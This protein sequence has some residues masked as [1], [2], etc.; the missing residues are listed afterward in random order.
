M[1]LVRRRLMTG[2][3]AAALLSGCPLNVVQTPAD[4]PMRRGP[5]EVGQAILGVTPDTLPLPVP[6]D[7]AF[8]PALATCD[9][10]PSP[11]MPPSEIRSV[12]YYPAVATSDDVSLRIRSRLATGAFPLVLFAHGR[13]YAPW[14]VTPPGIEASAT[15]VRQDFLKWDELLSHVASHGF[16]VVAPDLGWLLQ[17]LESRPWPDDPAA[18]DGPPRATL[19]ARL[20][21]QLAAR[22]DLFAD[23]M[24]HLRL[25]LVGHSTGAEACV[26]AAQ[27]L[28]QTKLLCML[29]PAILFP[30]LSGSP[31]TLVIGGTLDTGQGANPRQTF[32]SAPRP[33]TLVTLTGATHFGYSRL[34][35]IDNRTCPADDPSGPGAISRTVQAQAA[36]TFIAAAA[37]RYAKLDASMDPYL[38]GTA[39]T[40][41]DDYLHTEV[42]GDITV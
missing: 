24:N 36:G 27:K 8:T 6:A 31:A 3:G 7:L 12:V 21:A 2:A 33:R 15:D 25:T 10:G 19:L 39:E 5:F 14:C 17:T 30:D 32:D 11:Q 37:R 13:R 41:L 28:P 42:L 1:N 16:I 35:S 4:S 18:T 40:G 29:A 20:H 9:G 38:A 23:Q 26:A 22:Q 34:C